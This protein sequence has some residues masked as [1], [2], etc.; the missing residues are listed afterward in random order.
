M[1]KDGFYIRRYVQYLAAAALLCALIEIA[2]LIV[3]R[4]GD[5]SFESKILLSLYAL[6]AITFIGV[7]VGVWNLYRWVHGVIVALC[8][9]GS[10]LFATLFVTGIF[11][12]G[13]LQGLEFIVGVLLQPA[14]ATKLSLEIMLM[15]LPFILFFNPFNL[16]L[17]SRHVK[18]KSLFVP[19]Q[20]TAVALK[21]KEY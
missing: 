3:F 1:E 5:F 16:Y 19:E 2:F 20:K 11:L 18:V 10:L 6:L 8:V 17:F 21:T 15:L 13:F 14:Y 7:G 12:G 4:A 9:L